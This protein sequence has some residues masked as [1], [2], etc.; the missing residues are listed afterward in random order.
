MRKNEK[1]SKDLSYSSHYHCMLNA[2][3]SAIKWRK[4]YTHRHQSKSRNCITR[5]NKIKWSDDLNY[6]H[7]IYN[8]SPLHKY[9]ATYKKG[10]K[11]MPRI[12]TTTIAISRFFFFTLC[13]L[14]SISIILIC[15]EVGFR[16][17][18]WFW[19]ALNSIVCIQFYVGICYDEVNNKN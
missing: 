16:K 4:S 5:N 1:I 10:M 7:A 3:N 9:S 6:N 19:A 12:I 15:D 2:F 13:V 11:N 14:S 18:H 17:S 8:L